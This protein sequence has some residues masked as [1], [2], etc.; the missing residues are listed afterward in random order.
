MFYGKKEHY[1]IVEVIANKFKKLCDISKK[2]K[3]VHTIP[4]SHASKDEE[5][6]NALEVSF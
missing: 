1:E 5:L 3:L 6:Y 2:I 4:E